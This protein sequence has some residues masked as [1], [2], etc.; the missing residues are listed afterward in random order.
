MSYESCVLMFW[1]NTDAV[2]ITRCSAAVLQCPAVLQ[3]GINVA[4][5]AASD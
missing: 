4:A 3:E 1:M 5:A 2:S